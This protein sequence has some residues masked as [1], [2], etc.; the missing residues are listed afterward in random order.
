ME[1]FKKRLKAIEERK[2]RRTFPVPSGLSFYHNDYLGLSHDERLVSAGQRA[3]A[4]LGAGSKGS[5]LLGGHGLIFEE[6]EAAVAEFFRA[7][8]AL[9]F[10]TGYMANVACM[11]AVA[12]VCGRILS[13]EFNHASLIDGIRLSGISKVIVAHNQWQTVGGNADDCVVSEGL[14]SM[15]GDFVNFQDFQSRRGLYVLDEAHLAGVFFEKGAGFE[16]DWDRGVKVVTFGKGFGVS[17]ACVL[18]S[19]SFREYLINTSRPFIFSTAPPPVVPAMVLESL[20]VVQKES[21]RREALWA[22]SQMVRKILAPLIGTAGG[23]EQYSPIISVRIPG[24]DRALRFCESMRK[25]GVDLRAIRYPTVRVGEERV[26]ISLGL[27]VSEENTRL[28][29]EEFVKLWKAFS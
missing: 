11:V 16:V 2:E 6:A 1:R 5:R 20:A 23:Y 7:P 4:H 3:L 14:F 27:A 22:R 17:G 24:A 9:L 8:S 28:M 26:R 29:A 19:P 10:S 21:W 15:E 13:D 25:I 12:D 18:S